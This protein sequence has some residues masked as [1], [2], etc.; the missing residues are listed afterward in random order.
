MKLYYGAAHDQNSISYSVAI[1]TVN[2]E[3]K[4]AQTKL[5]HTDELVSNDQFYHWDFN[6]DYSYSQNRHV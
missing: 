4:Y 1:H 3:L 5:S 6:N 2:V